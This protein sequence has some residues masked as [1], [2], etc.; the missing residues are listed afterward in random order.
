MAQRKETA[1]MEIEMQE[2]TRHDI[3]DEEKETESCSWAKAIWIRIKLSTFV[4]T[5]ILIFKI[6]LLLTSAFGTPSWDLATDYLAA[7]KH[8]K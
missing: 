5:A 4:L 6:I 7:D 1:A 2:V 8:F 3:D